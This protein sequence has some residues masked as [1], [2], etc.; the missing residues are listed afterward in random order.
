MQRTPLSD[1]TSQVPVTLLIVRRPSS[2]V[3][4]YRR[5]FVSRSSI[6]ARMNT[7]PLITC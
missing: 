4:R 1:G 6:T 5:R 2:I 3:H 7:T